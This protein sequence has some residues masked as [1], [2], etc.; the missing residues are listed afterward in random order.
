MISLFMTT[1][2]QNDE[3]LRGDKRK[4]PPRGCCGAKYVQKKKKTAVLDKF[5][6]SDRFFIVIREPE[7]RSI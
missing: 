1:L 7:K 2:D 5:S 6:I 4:L 3:R